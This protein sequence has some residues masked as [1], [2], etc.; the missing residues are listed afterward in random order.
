MGAVRQLD[1]ARGIAR[2]LAM[3]YGKPVYSRRLARF[4]R[5]F[6]GSGMLCFDIGAH[7]GNRSRCWLNLGARVVAVEPQPDFAR[8]LGWWLGGRPGFTLV[9]SALAAR[10]G[11]VDLRVSRR[12][13]TVTTA[14]A[15]WITEVQ[16]T[17]GFSWVRWE[18]AVKVRAVT[19]DTLIGEHGRPDFCKIDVEGY[20]A[21]VLQ[22]LSVAL[23]LVSLEYLPPAI[24]VARRAVGRLADL[25]D[26]RF[27]V[28]VGESMTLLW[29]DW[30]P[31][32]D[33]LDWLDGRKPDEGSGD[34]YARLQS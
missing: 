6:V 12:T 21:E 31:M 17:S 24:D 11:T 29:A 9:E 28:S 34:I 20:E 15:E 7:V 30:R 14:S 4:Y 8:M 19:L 27:N 2:S 18:E 13:P 3:Y 26:Y 23:P 25:G 5:Q 22:G 16:K 33:V 10:P 1:R 32:A